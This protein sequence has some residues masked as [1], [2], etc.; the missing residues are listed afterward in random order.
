MTLNHLTHVAA[1][2]GMLALG[3]AHADENVVAR[4]V[5]NIGCH[6]VN[7]VCYVTLDGAA[8]GAAEN[9]AAAPAGS[10]QFRFDNAETADGR[11]T[12]AS[13]LA[14]FLSQRPVSVMIR[15]CS[16]QGV[17]SLLYYEIS[18]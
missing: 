7:G 9:C 16:V 3:T 13:L 6:H 12:Y 11:R 2:L 5:T 1:L 15:G 18:Q 17:P 10:N 14:A 8:F 4:R